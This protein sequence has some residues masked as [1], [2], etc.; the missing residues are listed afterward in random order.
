LCSKE[1]IAVFCV[2]VAV[3]QIPKI[4][5]FALAALLSHHPKQTKDENIYFN[6][7]V[8]KTVLAAQVYNR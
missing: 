3:S 8:Y 2:A 5:A 1:N 4:L 7:Q 6:F